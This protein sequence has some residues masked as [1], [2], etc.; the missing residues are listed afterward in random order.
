VTSVV[1]NLILVRLETVLV[2]DRMHPIKVVSDKGRVE[3]CFSPF[4][5]SVSVSAE[6]GARFAPNIP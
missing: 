4:G 1:W 3:S 5:Y 6:I 2:Q